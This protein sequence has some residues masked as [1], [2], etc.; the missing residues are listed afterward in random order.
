M[1]ILPNKDVL[2]AQRRGEILLYKSADSTLTEAAKLDVYWKT[3]VP[4]VNAEEG[5][6]GLKADPNFTENKY[7]YVFYSPKEEWVNRLS[8]FKFENDRLNLETEQVILEFY[9]QRDICCHT[10]GSI[11]FD[12]DGLLYLS[13]GD[14]ATP[15]NQPQGPYRLTGF[16]PIDDRPGY[17]QYDAARSSGE[18]Q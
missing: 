3:D 17:E 2:I 11:A 6:L 5:V 13:T 15:F 18:H 14:N 1:T 10:G 8:R 16:A 7:V 9:S 4:R 12:K